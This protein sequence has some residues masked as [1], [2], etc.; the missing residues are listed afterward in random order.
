MCSE[1]IRIQSTRL[2]STWHRDYRKRKVIETDY[3]Q[4]DR[5]LSLFEQDTHTP[6]PNQTPVEKW[7][8]KWKN[9]IENSRH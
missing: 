9:Q 4:T 1:E 6:N 8:M 3:Q 2:F 7:K 5:L